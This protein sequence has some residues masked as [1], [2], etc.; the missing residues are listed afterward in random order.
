MKKS[1]LV[2]ESLFED[3]STQGYEGGNSFGVQK[4][5]ELIK[6]H[7]PFLKNVSYD[8]LGERGTPEHP[9]YGQDEQYA[10]WDQISFQT[11][12][13]KIDESS[14]CVYLIQPFD[15]DQIYAKIYVDTVAYT[16]YGEADDEYTHE[17]KPVAIEDWDE[18]R[19]NSIIEDLKEQYGVD[20]E[21]EYDWEDEEEPLFQ[22]RPNQYKWSIKNNR[23]EYIGPGK[24]EFEWDENTKD[25]RRKQ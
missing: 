5:L 8:D 11:G 1:K 14:P 2:K 21:E 16:G 9:I 18:E 17:I 22:N 4:C 10:K 13:E 25:Y 19:Y 7:M 15:D 6:Q 24:E 20:D 3:F 12:I 23:W